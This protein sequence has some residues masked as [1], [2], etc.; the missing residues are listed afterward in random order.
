MKQLIVIITMLFSVDLIAQATVKNYCADGRNC[1]EEILKVLT[2][3]T[4]SYADS[5]Q[6]AGKYVYV[7]KNKDGDKLQ[8]FYSMFTKGEDIDIKIKGVKTYQ[9]SSIVAQYLTAYKIYNEYFGGDKSITDIK[10]NELLWNY[11]LVN[12][13]K[14]LSMS[15][16][17][18]K[19]NWLMRF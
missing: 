16:I 2:D 18:N 10:Q 12:K 8:F 1:H 13:K 11:L 14:I 19:G 17:D 6:I 9:L 7:Y 4:F 5:T 15:P 3:Y